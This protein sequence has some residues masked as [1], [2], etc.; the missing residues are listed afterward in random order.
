MRNSVS[1][2]EQKLTKGHFVIYLQDNIHMG[3]DDYVT[4]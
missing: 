4:L 1:Y 3:T 2:P